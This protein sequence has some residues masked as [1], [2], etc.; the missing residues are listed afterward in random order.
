M[1]VLQ[2]RNLFPDRTMDVLV[3][4]HPVINDNNVIDLVIQH[5]IG[6][7][8]ISL[9]YLETGNLCAHVSREN[10]TLIVLQHTLLLGA[11]DVD[12][13][14]Y[15]RMT[16]ADFAISFIIIDACGSL[17]EEVFRV[18]CV[19]RWSCRGNDQMHGSETLHLPYGGAISREYSHGRS[20]S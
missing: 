6:L 5:I 3:H 17:Q 14:Q 7:E 13:V 4:L 10:L 8:Y 19:V 1:R 9:I 16:I 11:A 15:V 12:R 2:F 20:G 18:G